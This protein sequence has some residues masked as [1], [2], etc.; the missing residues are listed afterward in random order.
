M[1]PSLCS[2][3]SKTGLQNG[4]IIKDANEKARVGSDGVLPVGCSVSVGLACSP[5]INLAA[6]KGALT[7]RV[8]RY[9]PSPFLREEQW[10]GLKISTGQSVHLSVDLPSSE[11]T[12][13]L[14]L[15]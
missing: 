9:P 2:V 12:Q 15:T 3:I 8:C 7:S 14:P 5:F 13:G 11:T 6:L 4:S 1:T 10:E